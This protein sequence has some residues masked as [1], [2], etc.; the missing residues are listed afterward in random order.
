[1]PRIPTRLPVELSWG[2][3]PRIAATRAAGRARRASAHFARRAVVLGVAVTLLGACGDEIVDDSC[4][5]DPVATVLGTTYDGAL[6]VDVGQL[7]ELTAGVYIRDLTVGTGAEATVGAGVRVRYAGW[8]PDGT[9]FD[10]GQNFQFTV[11]GG[12][13]IL[14]WDRGVQG[15]RVGGVRQ[16]VLSPNVAYGRCGLG[17]IPG[18]SVLVFEVE[19]LE[20][21]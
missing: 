9:Q 6:G 20:V 12:Q 3:Q 17:A 21:A 8:L 13:V 5:N 2:S 10:S 7:T 1:M 11:G 19:L 18:N 16:L 14:G 4:S 15:L